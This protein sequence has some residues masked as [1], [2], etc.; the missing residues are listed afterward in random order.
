MGKSG[1]EAAVGGKNIVL[2]EKR[3]L[4][5]KKKKADWSSSVPG[6][7]VIQALKFTEIGSSLQFSF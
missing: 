1:R 4:G 2:V 6:V 3:R 5:E 7:R